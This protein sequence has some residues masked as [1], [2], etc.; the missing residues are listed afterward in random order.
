LL[1]ELKEIQTKIDEL[2]NKEK[3]RLVPELKSGHTEGGWDCPLSPIGYC[4]YN[5]F[6]D[7]ALDDC[8]Y[9]HLPDERK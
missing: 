3:K 9:C 4:V 5:H 6:E 2:I 7:P 1:K 8:I